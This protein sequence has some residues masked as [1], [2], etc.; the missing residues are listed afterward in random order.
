MR[1]K[2]IMRFPSLR[3]SSLVRFRCVSVPVRALRNKPDRTQS[4][5]F[6]REEN[7]KSQKKMVLECLNQVSHQLT[8]TNNRVQKIA[9]YL[10]MN[11]PASQADYA[12]CKRAYEMLIDALEGMANNLQKVCETHKLQDE[13]EE[14]ICTA[15]RNL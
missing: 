11:V 15:V 9:G 13:K 2:R 12:A 4:T 5:S 1:V 7:V 6:W 8:Q 10:S 3:Q 14:K